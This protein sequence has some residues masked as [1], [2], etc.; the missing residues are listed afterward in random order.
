MDTE[1][2][3]AELRQLLEVRSPNGVSKDEI[4]QYVSLTRIFVA[5]KMLSIRKTNS[6]AQQTK[7]LNEIF[8]GQ[9]YLM[10][11]R[12]MTDYVLPEDLWEIAKDFDNNDPMVYDYLLK[13]IIEKQYLLQNS[14]E[15]ESL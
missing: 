15:N 13:K 5:E 4:A 9:Y 7:L 8:Q 10:G 1:A 2:K 14:M 6:K 3:L 11:I 12:I